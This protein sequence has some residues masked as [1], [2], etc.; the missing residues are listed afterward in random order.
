M[1]AKV[2]KEL[3][4]KVSISGVEF[5]EIPKYISIDRNRT[6]WVTAE[7]PVWREE[8]G[9]FQAVGAFTCSEEVLV[10]EFVY[11]LLQKHKIMEI[12]G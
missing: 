4:P 3:L 8:P 9:Y 11:Q 10:S 5:W 2:F 6:I 12:V 1:I 7:L